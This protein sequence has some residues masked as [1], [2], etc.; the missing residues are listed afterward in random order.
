MMLVSEPYKGRRKSKF[1]EHLHPRSRTSAQ[2]LSLY[3]IANRLTFMI[4]HKWISKVLL[5][6]AHLAGRSRHV[7]GRYPHPFSERC[8]P[9]S[10]SR[11]EIVDHVRGQ[12]CVNSV[13][14]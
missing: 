1:N 9:N 13:S 6:S 2:F 12:S 11:P 10:P 3:Y 7:V 4:I 5:I 8:G 14:R